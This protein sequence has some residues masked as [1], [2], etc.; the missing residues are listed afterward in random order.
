MV[1]ST[2]A[3][4]WKAYQFSD[5]FAAGS[6]YV[7]N[8]VDK[9]FC[10]PDCDARPIT[11]LKSEV[12]FMTHPSDCMTYG[13]TPCEYCEPLSIPAIDVNLL[14]ECVATINN[15]IG[16]LPPLLD[17]NEENNNLKIK[18]NILES[19]KVNEVNILNT[20]N[21]A[22]GITGGLRKSSAP[23][24]G[25]DGKFNKDFEHTSLS[26]NDSDH[27]R[28]VDLACRHL[29]LA[30]AVSIFH[31][32]ML[33][34][35]NSPE[36]GSP[37]DESNSGASNPKKRRRRG[38]VLGFKE[39]A[40]KSK[41]SAWHFHRV[42]KSVTGLTPKSYGDKCWEFIKKYKEDHPNVMNSSDSPSSTSS[43]N[44]SIKTTATSV[45]GTPYYQKR[46][47]ITSSPGLSFSAHKK[48]KLEDN[49]T[50]SNINN[51]LYPIDN[52]S[53]SGPTQA[54]S[55]A[56]FS[57]PTNGT[58]SSISTTPVVGS[59][60]ISE[61]L[62]K[63]DSDNYQ[64]N[65]HYNNQL[66]SSAPDLTRLQSFQQPAS[67]FP[68]S[69]ESD[70]CMMNN[71]NSNPNPN[72]KIYANSVKGNL[73]YSDISPISNAVSNSNMNYQNSNRN[74]TTPY[75]FN[76]PAV[77]PMGL[78]ISEN[79]N[80]Y[81]DVFNYTLPGVPGNLATLGLPLEENHTVSH[82]GNSLTPN[83][84]GVPVIDSTYVGGGSY[85]FS[86]DQGKWTP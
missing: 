16:F 63:V 73:D 38:G 48:I 61:E 31:P 2:E 80:N 51:N 12:K 76:I 30:A 57:F 9:V 24:F 7:C 81:N 33:K 42:F 65:G 29:A 74:M 37:T 55:T 14:V 1:Y 18:A 41:L 58:L 66:Y 40:A 84:E 54:S 20:I 23:V 67:L 8:K 25:Y 39:L 35:P 28:L 13:Y 11:N 62:A 59:T 3:A 44:S 15:Q 79:I 86:F 68:Q 70:S 52:F 69:K 53:I 50:S 72:P 17:D 47:S 83:V 71:L 5:P 27:Y 32:N 60:I 22:G 64:V 45:G 46:K 34:R 78:D 49:H 21:N 6:F 43:L 26:K 85:T 10:R 75:N 77:S 4:K 82:F 19:K 56:M 36:S